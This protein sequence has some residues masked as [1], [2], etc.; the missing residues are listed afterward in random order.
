MGHYL[1]SRH[2]AWALYF[3]DLNKNLC[4]VYSLHLILGIIGPLFLNK[5]R[6]LLH[7][8]LN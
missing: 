3:G 1:V 7:F 8:I 6:P 5:I 4:V 2:F